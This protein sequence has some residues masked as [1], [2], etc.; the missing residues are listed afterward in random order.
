ML[1]EET[2]AEKKEQKGKLGGLKGK[3][4]GRGKEAEARKLEAGMEAE[5]QKAEEDINKPVAAPE[6]QQ[7]AEQQEGPEEKQAGLRK[8]SMKA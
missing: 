4:T 2:V 7:A 8:G 5:K 1:P 6:G 3:I